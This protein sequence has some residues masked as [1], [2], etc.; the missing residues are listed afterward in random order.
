[1]PVRRIALEPASRLAVWARRIA[2]F[3]LPAVLLAIIIER[4]G[5]LEIVPVLATFGAALGMAAVAI[6][7]AALA[8]IGIWRHGTDGLGAALTAIVIGVAL[9]AYPAYFAVLAYRLPAI[10]DITTDPIDPPR[11]E[12]IGRLRSRQANPIAY[13]GLYAAEQQRRAYPDIGP[14]DTEVNAQAAYDATMAIIAK[15]R[16]QV[17]NTHP[18]QP[19]R[20]GYVEAVA[21]T[22]IMGFRDD[23]A[24]RIRALRQ[25]ARIDV[26]SASRYGRHDFGTNAARIRTLLEQIDDAASE[27]AQQPARPAQK[28]KAPPPQKGNQPSKGR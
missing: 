3:S 12:T 21:R 16:W 20:D 15:R 26:R 18:P 8:L 11:F 13:A 28:A 14:L 9:L 10:A 23:V 19:G 25:G 27:K 17:I 7:L 6:V 4:A 22:P 5:L 2:I 24:V 1:M